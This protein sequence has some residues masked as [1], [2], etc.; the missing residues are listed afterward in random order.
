MIKYEFKR[1]EDRWH[2]FWQERGFFEVDTKDTRNK[3]YYLNM[4]PYPSGEMHVGHGR[5]Y[6]IGDA[7]TRFYLMNGYNVLNPMGWDAFGLPAENAA[8]RHRSHPKKWTFES[9]EKYKRQFRELG[10]MFDWTREVTTCKPDYYKWTQWLFLKFYQRGLAYRAKAYVNWCPGCGTV[11]ANEQV[12]ES[13]CERCDAKVIKR[14]LTQWFF[15]IT[16]YAER[17][18]K[19]L[20]LLEEWPARVKK[21]QR[22]WIGKSEGVEAEF[23]VVDSDEVLQIFTTRPD[24]LFGATFMALAPEHPLVDR[25]IEEEADETKQNGI[26]EQLSSF[27]ERVRGESEIKRSAAEV[28]KEGIFTGRYAI[29]P[30]NGEKIPIYIANYVLMEYGTGA[31]M[32][33]PAH[34]ERDFEFAKKYDLP[35]IRVIESE[36]SKGE[37]REAYTGEGYLVN[38]GK[39]NGLSC[40]E[41]FQKI[42]EYLSERNSGRFATSYRLRDWLISRQRYW[43]APIP[44]VYCPKCG[45][46]PVPEEELPVELPDI[47]FVGKKGLAEVEQFVHT[48]CPKC[49]SDAKRETDTMDTFVDSSWY[50]LRYI[51]PHDDEKPFDTQL[52][53]GWLPVD[54]YVGGVEHAILHLMYSRFVTKA[55]KDM[56]YLNFDEPFARL[57][58]Q[59]MVCLGGEAMSSSRGNVVLPSEVIAEYGTDTERLY[60]MFMGPPEGDIEWSAADIVGSRRFLKRVWWLA[61]EFSSEIKGTASEEID[62]DELTEEDKRVW[63]K[64][65][66]TIKAVTEDIESFSFNTAVSS[67]M[68]LVNEIY[69]Y[70]E[71]EINKSLLKRSIEDLILML[72]PFVPFITEELWRVIGHEESILENDWPEYDEQAL[73]A[74]QQEIVIQINGK[75]RGR[76]IVPAEMS[77]NKEELRRRALQ[78]KAVRRRLDG[79]EVKQV[80]V[81]P[82]RLVNLVIVKKT[83]F[84]ERNRS[85][86]H[87]KV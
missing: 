55:L 6:I 42:G 81:V 63:R 80:I 37:L 84:S 1:I 70:I 15:R 34:D 11:L 45:I 74:E 10:I 18:L 5:N 17:L 87:R 36:E 40:G 68:E 60:T 79:R 50:Y 62:L 51:C 72:S 32:A 2:D 39:F 64:L 82:G 24:T 8:I 9:I 76:M 78:E 49:G 59:G 27:V 73:L 31:I 54:Q 52:V 46:V 43:G 85:G 83:G 47:E 57:F 67:A 30:V 41:A 33:V 86:R 44:I 3:F 66:A 29:N 48:T 19:D 58:T 26:Y 20:D 21:M 13:R 75:V 14:K 22:N 4:F 65:N 53:N 71:G 61:N 25:I 12:I 23:K 7:L 69:S 28:E 35:I 16:D 56:G 77:N 38:S